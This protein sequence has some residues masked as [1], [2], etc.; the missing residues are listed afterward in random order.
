MKFDKNNL[1]KKWVYYS[2]ATCSAVVLY[3][4][5]SHIGIVFEAIGKFFH[6][7]GPV[8]VGVVIAYVLSPMVGWYE[9]KVLK[10]V[11]IERTRHN[12][13][14]LL[15]ILTVVLIF[16]VLVYKLVPQIVESLTTL[17]MNMRSYV[18]TIN[19]LM[20]RLEEMAAA[21]QIDISFVTNMSSNFLKTLTSRLPTTMDG[22]IS[23]SYNIGMNVANIMIGF[24]LAI[25]FL[26]DSRHMTGAV[27]DFFRLILPDKEFA[28]IAAIW[29]RC[30][31]ILIRYIGCSL[32]DAAIVGVA[33]GIFMS[34]MKMPYVVLIS[35]IVGITNLAPTFGPIVG[36]AIG[37][38]ILILISPW[39]CLWFLIFTFILQT[40]DGY[41]LK[42]KL[43]GNGL[44]V[45]GVW[46]LIT[47][48][49]GGR[50]IG[51]AGILLAIPIA[52]ILNFLYQDLIRAKMG[53]RIQDAGDNKNRNKK[54]SSGKKREEKGKNQESPDA[55]DTAGEEAREETTADAEKQMSVT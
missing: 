4:A 7:I 53:S 10:A 32:L 22:I 24:I 3:L 34:V 42:P 44:G 26:I 6:V 43:F 46:I 49:I 47:I 19:K 37:G 8:L 18:Y 41:V 9:K 12:L 48:I 45:P 16:F 50:M 11:P 30:N 52:A 54:K 38:L 13:S 39:Y 55:D 35:V 15:T 2:I 25:Y 31:E 20:G 1:D 23:T 28:N 27:R 40:I 36:G 5:L 33:N 14:V 21:A 51:V 29:G 17:V